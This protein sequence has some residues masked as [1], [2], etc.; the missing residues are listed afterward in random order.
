MCRRFRHFRS[1]MANVR[2]PGIKRM[3]PL[4][5]FHVAPQNLRDAPGLSHAA[6]RRV[7]A[8]GVEDLAD[9]TDTGLAEALL[10]T[11]KKSARAPVLAGIHSEPGVDERPDQPCPD[12]PLVISRVARAQIAVV[13]RPV[14]GMAWR[15]RAQTERRQQPIG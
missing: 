14:I 7:M 15:E 3:S 9:R 10:E 1:A 11:V 4:R 5:G 6:A 13:R 12:R 8:L 2:S